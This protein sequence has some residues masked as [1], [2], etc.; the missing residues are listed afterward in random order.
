MVYPLPCSL[1]CQRGAVER[2]VRTFIN[3]NR[4]DQFALPVNFRN[5]SFPCFMNLYIKSPVIPSLHRFAYAFHQI[6]KYSVP[7]TPPRQ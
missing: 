1:D 2:A 4:V 5:I 7:K 3:A 6:L